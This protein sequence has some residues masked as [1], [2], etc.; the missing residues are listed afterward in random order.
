VLEDVITR[1][2]ELDLRLA[3]SETEAELEFTALLTAQ[4]MTRLHRGR[5]RVP[6]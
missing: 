1:S 5:H 6:L 4:T 3:G 2:R